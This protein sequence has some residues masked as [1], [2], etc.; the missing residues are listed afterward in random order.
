MA[1]TG[2]VAGELLESK[3]EPSLSVSVEMKVNLGNYS[4]ASA[5]VSMSGVTTETTEEQMDRL[6]SN[7]RVAWEKLRA[8]LAEKV[9]RL[10][11]RVHEGAL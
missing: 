9:N 1:K 10:K 6:L 2:E 8:D 3:Q 11:E 5:F 7:G 4:S